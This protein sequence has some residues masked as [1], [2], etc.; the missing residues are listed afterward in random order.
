MLLEIKAFQRAEVPG[1]SWGCRL[2][3]GADTRSWVF[4]CRQ[5]SSCPREAK[6]KEGFA[7][8]IKPQTVLVGGFGAICRSIDSRP[9]AASRSVGPFEL[10]SAR[11]SCFLK[12]CSSVRRRFAA[13]DRNPVGGESREVC[14][15]LRGS[16]TPTRFSSA[17]CSTAQLSARLALRPCQPLPP[18]SPSQDSVMQTSHLFLLLFKAFLCC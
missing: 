4:P 1:G 6:L 13:P 2:S 9:V 8:Y 5:D 14:A 12:S 18:F 15:A 11:S 10:Q 3:Q 16:E 17:P 7:N